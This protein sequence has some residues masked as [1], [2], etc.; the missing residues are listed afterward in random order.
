MI[1]DKLKDEK[2]FDTFISEDSKRINAEREKKYVY[3]RK[4][5]I[6]KHEV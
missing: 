5:K 6:R 3:C 2:Y 1:R 4:N